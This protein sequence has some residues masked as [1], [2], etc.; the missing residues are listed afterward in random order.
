MTSFIVDFQFTKT[1][2]YQISYTCLFSPAKFIVGEEVFT[3]TVNVGDTGV[4][5]SMMRRH[6]TGN[7]RWRKDGGDEIH[8]NDG[9]LEYIFTGPIQSSDEGLYE[10]YDDGEREDA[11][12]ALLRLIVRG[13]NIRE[14]VLTVIIDYHDYR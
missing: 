7:I 8:S 13:K 4:S 10:I 14:M 9:L 3:K 12:G 11:K 2:R 5:I 6:G 1:R